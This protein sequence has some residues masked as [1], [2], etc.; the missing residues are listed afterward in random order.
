MWRTRQR[1]GWHLTE[2]KIYAHLTQGRFPDGPYEYRRLAVPVRRVRASARVLLF[3]H[4]PPEKETV[5]EG[6]R[7][8]RLELGGRAGGDAR[9]RAAADVLLRRSRDQAAVHEEELSVSSPKTLARIAGLLY[10]GTSV[11]FVFAVQVRSRIIEPGDATDTVHNIRA[12]ATLFRVALVADLVSWA[13]FLVTA[14]ALY[15]LL[16]HA[17]QVAA[18]AMV[19]FVAVMVAVG[20]SNTVNQYSALTIATSAEYAN[21]LGRAGTNAMVLIFTDVQGNGLDINELFFGLWLLPL[22]YLVIKSQYFPRVIG[23]FLIIAGL[24]WIA[25]FLVI[26][27]AP[28]LKGVISLLGVGSDGELVFIG[29]LL[30]R[31]ARGRKPAPAV[32][33]S[34]ESPSVAI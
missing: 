33:S 11:P 3:E 13:G 20:Y 14:L 22:S 16:K 1:S 27:L 12:S 21:A 18:L 28:S 10:L 9:Q 23:V 4:D 26:L 8:A 7:A 24:S 15:L 32:A 30:V 29:W 19:A 6:V 17:N 34:R 25:Q 2:A 5:D 31:G